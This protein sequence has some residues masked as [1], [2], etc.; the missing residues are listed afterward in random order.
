VQFFRIENC[1]W[2][3]FNWGCLLFALLVAGSAAKGDNLAVAATVVSN[4]DKSTVCL[5]VGQ[6]PPAPTRTGLLAAEI[7]RQAF[8]IAARDGLGLPTRDGSLREWGASGPP[9]EL[10]EPTMNQ[11]HWQFAVAGKTPQEMVWEGDIQWDSLPINYPDMVVAA[12]R[13][14]RAGFVA[15]LKAH[16]WVG[17][18]VAFKPDLP[19]PAGCEALL[20]QLD[21]F[22]Q[23]AALRLVDAAIEKD[24]ESLPRL[25]VLVRAYANL[26]QLTRFHWS[27]ESKVYAARA[28]LYAQRMVSL[29]PNSAFALWHRAYSRA[30]AGLHQN[31]LDDLHDADALNQP[32]RP[33]WA[34]LLDAYCRYQTSRLTDLAVKDPTQKPLAMYLAYLTV[35]YSNSQGA[36][37]TV[38]QEALAANPNCLQ[39]IDAMCNDTGPGMLNEL[40]DMGPSVFG[41]ILGDRLREIFGKPKSVTDLLAG[42]NGGEV[43]PADRRTIWLAMI[44]AGS[45]KRDQVEPSLAALGRLIEE[46]EFAQCRRGGDFWSHWMGTDS[47]NYVKSVWPSVADHPYHNTMKAYGLWLEPDL[48]DAGAALEDQSFDLVTINNFFVLNNLEG[49]AKPRGKDSNQKIFDA[50]FR[51]L[52]GTS[53]DMEQVLNGYGDQTPVDAPW[54]VQFLNYVSPHSPLLIAEEIRDD[55]NSDKEAE[56]APLAADQPDVALA[57]GRHYVKTEQWDRAE[58]CLKQYITRSPD[59]T[60]YETL[61]GIYKQQHRDDRWLATLKEYLMQPDYGLQHMSVQV[62]IARYYMAKGDYADAIPFADQAAGTGAYDGQDCDAEARTGIGDF[63]TAEQL[64]IDNM[65][66]Y[67]TGPYDWFAWCVRTGHGDRTGA[68]TELQEYL[69]APGKHLTDEDKFEWAVLRMLQGDEAAAIKT[70]PAHAK[71]RR[72]VVSNLHIAILQD[73]AGNATERDKSLEKAISLSRDGTKLNK[74]CLLLQAAFQSGAAA[75]P[76]ADAMADLLKTAKPDDRAVIAYIA[77]R[78][79]DTRKQIDLATKYLRIGIAGNSDN[80]VDVLLIAD[81]LRKRGIDSLILQRPTTQPES[82][83]QP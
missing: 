23:F 55:W 65:N 11:Q 46:T 76:D 32:N 10:I 20:D 12:E 31:G 25:S 7:Y 34:D 41:N 30:L 18:P 52:D 1:T 19:A 40:N 16:G 26:S 43:N 69:A 8:L 48:K 61:A 2:H 6:W 49:E 71:G 44:D 67:N 3:P 21:E 75:T 63:A 37:M 62:K 60:G 73:V 51:N 79:L 39:L 74:F 47:S 54:C 14:S 33:A 83:T 17:N 22:S 81:A 59:V 82:S 24:G 9:G 28:L 66:H 42:L 72:G 56:W 80:T 15:A 4:S 64:L 57:L 53:F 13:L 27:I 68:A 45:P 70:F 77:A 29:H 36:K 35:Q 58:R 50:Y 78:C 38:A 5:D